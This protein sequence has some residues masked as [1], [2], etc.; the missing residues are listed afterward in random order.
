MILPDKGSRYKFLSPQFGFV[1]C[2]IPGTIYAFQYVNKWNLNLSNT[3]VHLF[4]L[5]MVTF[6][7]VSY[8]TA[9][10]YET[11]S[12]KGSLSIANNGIN[13]NFKIENWKIEFLLLI[14]FISL[15]LTVIFLI[16]NYGSN[17]SAAIFS[18]RSSVNNDSSIGNAL[19]GAVKLLR[20]IALSGGYIVLFLL[21]NG[22][23]YKNKRN[24]LAEWL[25]VILAVINGFMLGGRG[26]GIQLIVAAIVQ[27][28]ALK[29]EV[30]NSRKVSFKDII[31]VLSICIILFSSFIQLGTLLG[32]EMSFLNNNDYMAVYLSAELK[33]LDIFVTTGIIGHPFIQSLTL[34]NVINSLGGILSQ[35]SWIH[36]F[37]IPYYY[38]G[39]YSLGNV[40]TVFYP[41]IYDGGW[42]GVIV[43]TSIM[44]TICQIVYKR[45]LKSNKTSDISLSFIFYSYL[46]YIIIF[47]FFSNKFY[48]MI[49]NTS[50]VWTMV[51]WLILKYFLLKI[52]IKY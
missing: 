11:T 22:I 24:R 49:F 35:P 13:I 8:C 51:S 36:S 26:D 42:L 40:G 16:R 17:L 14:E 23:V 39:N 27:Y 46:F 48:E 37:A 5:G 4:L 9:F 18:Y 12:K 32:R 41:F 2:F 30:S 25:C 31:I 50:F 43:Y 10:L 19:P 47:S 3:T 45:F 6:V 52:R 21:L 34:Y 28:V 7:I 1:A 20:R 29:L 44:A 15:V 33:N 38:Y